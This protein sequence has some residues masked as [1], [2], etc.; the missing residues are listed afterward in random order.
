MEKRHRFSGIDPSKGSPLRTEDITDRRVLLAIRSIKAKDRFDEIAAKLNLSVSRLRHLF[1]EQTGWS[2]GKFSKEQKLWKARTVLQESFR[3][4]KETAAIA[5][6]SELSHFVRD[7][8]S[9]FGYRPSQTPAK[10]QGEPAK[11]AKE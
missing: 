3:S 9:R 11:S 6:F 2:P 8:K 7:Y 4:V 5:G 10:A 1:K